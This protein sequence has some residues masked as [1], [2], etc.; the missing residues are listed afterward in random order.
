MYIPDQATGKPIPKRDVSKY[1]PDI[2]LISYWWE[3]LFW[4]LTLQAPIDN[5]VPFTFFSAMNRSTKTKPHF[6]ISLMPSI[7]FVIKDNKAGINGET[8][9]WKQICELYKS[10]DE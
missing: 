10:R 2:V 4:S 8:L 5:F 1:D 6:L 7:Y 3:D 9:D